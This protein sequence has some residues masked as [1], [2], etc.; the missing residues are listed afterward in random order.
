MLK[1]HWLVIRLVNLGTRLMLLINLLLRR[2]LR[3]QRIFVYWIWRVKILMKHLLLVLLCWVLRLIHITWI[4]GYKLVLLLNILIL[5]VILVFK[6]IGV[7]VFSIRWR[8][9]LP[10]NLSGRSTLLLS[11]LHRHNMLHPLDNYFNIRLCLR[12]TL[13]LFNK[14]L[15]NLG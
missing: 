9:L 5:Y 10:R 7:L 8:G 13:K 2:L 12:K 11:L 1:L 3:L 14:A 4:L 15:V 6:R